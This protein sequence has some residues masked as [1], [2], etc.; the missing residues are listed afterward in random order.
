MSKIK[1]HNQNNT[2]RQDLLPSPPYNAAHLVNYS[3]I[4]L[5]YLMIWVIGHGVLT[6]R[7]LEMGILRSL[8]MHLSLHLVQFIVPCRYG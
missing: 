2:Q 5:L 3:L 6:Q 7:C 1:D 8:K 4:I